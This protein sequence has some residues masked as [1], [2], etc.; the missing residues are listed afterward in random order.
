MRTLCAKQG[1]VSST[2]PHRCGEPATDASWI[3]LPKE[4]VP[5]PRSSLAVDETV[6]AGHGDGP[7]P[8]LTRMARGNGKRIETEQEE[9]T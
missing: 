1:A 5:F 2:T 6:R 9:A 8:F 7:A 3:E 4:Q